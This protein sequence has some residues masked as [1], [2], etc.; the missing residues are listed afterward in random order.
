M[1]M[2]SFLWGLKFDFGEFCQPNLKWNSHRKP[3]KSVIK[4][5]YAFVNKAKL[6]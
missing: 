6:I 2:T 1:T 5:V 4:V 3:D